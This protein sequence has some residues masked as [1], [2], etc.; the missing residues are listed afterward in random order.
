MS[1]RSVVL[2]AAVLLLPG[3][4]SGQSLGAAVHAGTLGLGAEAALGLG[5][6]VVIRGGAGLLP[7]EVDGTLDDIDLTLE[8][9]RTWYNA[10]VDLYL[11][12]VVRIGGGMLWKPDDV[13]LSGTPTTSW[14]VGGRTFTPEELGTL[15]GL[16]DSGQRAPYVL[17]GFGKHTSSGVGLSLDIGAA[18]LKDPAVSLTSEGGTFSDG[19]ELQTRLDAEAR[20]FEED[21][22]AYMNIWP[23]LNLGLRF[24]LGG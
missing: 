23:I 9:P 16:I 11:T 14:D 17:I 18:F 13:L 20:N 5:G 8:F 3:S 1:K 2:A 6:V 19:V 12:N 15:S 21:A 10:G 4:A 24:G 22:P 7:L